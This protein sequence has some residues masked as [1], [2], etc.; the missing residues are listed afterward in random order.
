MRHAQRYCAFCL[1]LPFVTPFPQWNPSVALLRLVVDRVFPAE[2]AVL[3]HLET[4]G[5]VLLV[6]HGVAVSLLALRTPKGHFYAHIRHLLKFCLP[7]SSPAMLK[8]RTHGQDR[9]IRD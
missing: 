7:V 1:L 3:L 8:F 9:T 6:L 2:F 4:I 5:V